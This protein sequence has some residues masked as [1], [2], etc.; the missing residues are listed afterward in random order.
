METDNLH[1]RVRSYLMRSDN[2]GQDWECY[3]ENAHNPSNII[4]FDETSLAATAFH[5]TSA[6]RRSSRSVRLQRP[7]E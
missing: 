6:S 7:S 2:K 4:S 1:E 5:Q 3:S